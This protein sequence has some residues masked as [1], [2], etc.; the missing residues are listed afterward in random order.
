[1]G[2]AHV[3]N[4][5]A[6]SLPVRGRARSVVLVASEETAEFLS[7]FLGQSSQVMVQKMAKV[8]GLDRRKGFRHVS[9]TLLQV[10][11]TAFVSAFGVHLWRNLIDC[12]SCS[13]APP[14][15]QL[16]A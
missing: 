11:A 5:L 10:V 16:G 7:S 8:V 6:L 15:V 4:E 12:H 3:R 1:M 9:L 13:Q 14:D 2:C